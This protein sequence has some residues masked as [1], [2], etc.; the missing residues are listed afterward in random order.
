MRGTKIKFDASGP[1]FDWS[2]YLVDFDT[3]VQN[4]LVN[5]GTTLGSDPLYPDRGTSLMQDAAQGRMVNKSWANH[6]ANFAALATL[7]FI[8]RTDVPANLQLLND[9]Q[10]ASD[11]LSGQQVELQIYALAS[12]GTT[13]GQ[14]VLM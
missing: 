14:Q 10:M 6:S 4:A 11:K 5:V 3:T 2:I 7:A 1:T 13:A 12:D 8:R 9:F